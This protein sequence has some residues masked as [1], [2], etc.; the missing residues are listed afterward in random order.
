MITCRW[1]QDRLLI[2]LAGELDARLAAK[3]V[4]HLEKCGRCTRVAEELS[5]ARETVEGAIHSLP[6]VATPATLEGRVLKA[7]RDLPPPQK[8]VGWWTASLWG[9]NPP[10]RRTVA[11]A[12]A[13]T[14]AFAGGGVGFLVG[15]AVPP[16]PQQT[17]GTS[18]PQALNLALLEA[19]H[20]KFLAVAQPAQIVD[21]EAEKVAAQ[22]QKDVPFGV[23]GADLRLLDARLLGGRRCQIQ[24]ES[25][26]LFLYDR[27]GERVS[28]FQTD[29]RKLTL[30]RLQ[31]ESFEE[32]CF[33]V[34]EK[35]GIS[36][37]FWCWEGTNYI[38]VAQ[39]SPRDLLNL[40]SAIAATIAE[41]AIKKD[42]NVSGLSHRPGKPSGRLRYSTPEN[43]STLIT[44]RMEKRQ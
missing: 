15:R 27:N 2:Y 33:V 42:A 38:L 19:D 5:E 32:G 13:L 18:V 25:V 43:H 22:L 39:T 1:V 35:E 3:L 37:A 28:L 40:A 36:Y 16:S 20:R 10:I 31:G 12:I 30:P 7:V 44:I 26:A 21:P 17:G 23:H 8:R 4:R 24:G 9:T 29:A 6:P 14:V 34:G 11:A 41:R